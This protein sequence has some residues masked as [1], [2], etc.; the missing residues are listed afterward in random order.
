M[1]QSAVRGHALDQAVEVVIRRSL[2]TD[3]VLV[4]ATS[5][6]D[7][8]IG[9]ASVTLAYGPIRVQGTQENTGKD[10]SAM[11]Q[12][13]DDEEFDVE[14]SAT[15]AKG[16]AVGDRP[17]DTTDDP[18]FTSSDEGVFSYRLD[19]DNPRKATVVGGLPGSAVGTI[20]LGTIV[21]THAVDVVPA[22]V[23]TVA[24]TEGTVRKQGA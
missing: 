22:A 10:G 4:L 8:L 24:I 18:T 19:P 16:A 9:P 21:A 1:D 20:T 12:I 23:A 6:Y 14:L 5:F 15:D 13:H 11:A 17:G 3:Q 7:W 2:N